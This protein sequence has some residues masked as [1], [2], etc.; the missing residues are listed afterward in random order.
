MFTETEFDQIPYVKPTHDKMEQIKICPS[1][2][3]KL[4]SGLNPSKSQAPDLIHPRILKE[5]ANEISH[6]LCHLFQQSLSHGVI[7]DDWKTANICPLYKKNERSSP[8]NYRPV[9]L[10]S[11]CCKLLEHIICSNLMKHLDNNNV[12][13]DLQ[14]ASE[15]I[16]AAKHSSFM[17]SMT[18]QSALNRACK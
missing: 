5:L 11:I 1:G 17:L 3:A 14:H 7:P 12:L 16:E 13:T 2:V 9:S 18:G 4:L 10:T 6:V 8:C 15:K